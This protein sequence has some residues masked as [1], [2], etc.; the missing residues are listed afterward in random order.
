MRRRIKQEE[1]FLSISPM[2][3]WRITFSDMITLLMTF[4]VMIVAMGTLNEK[5]V[6]KRLSLNNDK[7]DVLNIPEAILPRSKENLLSGKSV[8]SVDILNKIK[9]SFPEDE[10]GFFVSESERGMVLSLPASLIFDVPGENLNK[11]ASKYLDVI[12]SSLKGT[13]DFIS[14]EGHT[15]KTG[16]D[17]ADAKLSLGMAAN[18]LDYFIYESG[19]SPTRFSIAGYGSKRP[20][21]DKNAKMSV[22]DN[23]RLEIVILKLKPYTETA[24]MALKE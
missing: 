20:S 17:E 3:N 13:R 16:D 9:L 23:N 18:T 10:K 21:I 19:M 8:L 6:M 4:F 7:T 14:I 12:A 15:A 22:S 1:S 2:D 11:N 24:G 5:T